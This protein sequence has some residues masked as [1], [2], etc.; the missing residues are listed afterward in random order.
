MNQP[1][2]L[3]AKTAGINPGGKKFPAAKEITLTP[4]ALTARARRAV[5]NFNARFGEEEM[6][7][8][9][10][11]KTA[12]IK[13]REVNIAKMRRAVKSACEECGLPAD[14]ILTEAQNAVLAVKSYGVRNGRRNF[15]DYNKERKVQ[16]RAGKEK[17]RGKLDYAR[18]DFS[19][20]TN[21]VPARM[22]NKIICGGGAELLKK[23]PDNCADLVFT[24][25]PYNFGLDYA[26][27]GDDKK[28]DEYF[29]KLFAVLEE[30]IRVVKY[31]GRIAVNVQ[32]LYSDYMP[33]HHI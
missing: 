22:E 21:A 27:A 1:Q 12:T 24:S 6:R 4:P 8:A 32:P 30:C 28:W 23:L 20:E 31:G 19:R 18:A 9:C 3:T 10:N 5:E 2:K 25:P 17:L 15:A 16:N 29:S 26:R 33:S 14:N 11:G 13:L 7:V